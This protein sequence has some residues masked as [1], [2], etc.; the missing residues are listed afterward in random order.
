MATTTG[1]P[2]AEVRK[3]LSEYDDQELVAAHLAGH[4]GAFAELYDRYRDRLVHFIARRTGDR[5][6][7]EDLVQEAFIRVTPSASIRPV[8]EVLDVDLHDLLEPGEE[9]ASEPFAQPAGPL[10]APDDA[11]GAGASSAAVRGLVD[12]VRRH[13]PEALPQDLVEKTVEELPEHH[14]LVF[15]LR[16]LQGRATRRSPRSPASIWHGEEPSASGEDEL[17]GAIEPI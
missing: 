7:A 4:P 17:R 11:L 9:R 10:P 16:E 8:E 6:R 15:K 14:R 2:E 3:P 13:V 12:C 1:K 5:D